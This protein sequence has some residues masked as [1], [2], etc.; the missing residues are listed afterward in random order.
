MDPRKHKRSSS[1]HPEERKR[2]SSRAPQPERKALPPSAPNPHRRGTMENPE[3]PYSV[4]TASEIGE[5]EEEE[6]RAPRGRGST[7]PSGSSSDRPMPATSNDAI[8]GCM[9]VIAGM[10]NIRANPAMFG[11]AFN[12]LYA[13]AIMLRRHL[14]VPVSTHNPIFTWDFD[15]SILP[16]HGVIE[17]LADHPAA[18]T[19][20]NYV[21]PNG[22]HKFMEFDLP[23]LSR[24]SPYLRTKA[25]LSALVLPQNDPVLPIAINVALLCAG[26]EMAASKVTFMGDW[27]ASNNMLACLLQ[28]PMM[29]MPAHFIRQAIE[30]KDDAGYPIIL[31]GHIEPLV[32]PLYPADVIFL[33]LV[34]G[35]RT[36]KLGD[37]SHLYGLHLLLYAYRAYSVKGY[38]ATPGFTESM[39]RELRKMCRVDIIASLTAHVDYL[40]RSKVQVSE[41]A[42]DWWASTVQGRAVSP[43]T[44]TNAVAMFRWT[45]EEL[46]RIFY[47]VPNPVPLPFSAPPPSSQA[48]GAPPPPPLQRSK[49]STRDK[50]RSTRDPSSTRKSSAR[51]PS[52]T[53]KSS[54]R[55][56]SRKPSGRSSQPRRAAEEEEDRLPPAPSPPLPPAHTA[57][58]LA[59]DDDD[60]DYDSEEEREAR[61]RA[62][63]G[64]RA[65][66]YA[67]DDARQRDRPTVPVQ[68]QP[69]DERG[70]SGRSSRHHR[71][72]GG[73]GEEVPL[74]RGRPVFD[75][76]DQYGGNS[77]GGIY[78]EPD[79]ESEDDM[80]RDLPGVRHVEGVDRD[81]YAPAARTPPTAPMLRSS[82]ARQQVPPRQ[83]PDSVTVRTTHA[84]GQ[85]LHQVHVPAGQ[86]ATIRLNDGLNIRLGGSRPSRDESERERRSSRR[87]EDAQMERLS[88][89]LS[90]M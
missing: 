83:R 4:E 41:H 23:Q 52:S 24:N 76:D 53:R 15:P 22:E 42:A 79:S 17:V 85:T 9:A 50:Q 74:P 6:R 82:H 18:F 45:I 5:R 36:D 54:T 16:H 30:V 21:E 8:T 10:G 25:I 55:D 78:A 88:R 46:H 64:R 60:D 58:P 13:L 12:G 69:R 57:Q 35:T 62:R 2:H 33:C 75:D 47:G 34:E 14:G 51:D 72:S 11:A 65:S 61:R 73:Y 89:R 43:R 29:T 27:N 31:R 56:S 19:S 84:P 66:V 32:L 67:A 81:R 26:S 80:R 20:F 63:H 39:W 7:R 77:H 3:T 1:K 87:I 68:E 86:E 38:N 71:S 90:G 70:R 44:R 48:F 37:C 40:E 49:S 59:V 28:H